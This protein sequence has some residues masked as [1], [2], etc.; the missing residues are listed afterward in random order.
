MRLALFS[1]IH[2]EFEIWTPP[3][4]D[5]DVVVLAGDIHSKHHG[6]QWAKE[7]FELPVI[8]ILG[9]HEYY[10]FNIQSI[11]RKLKEQSKNSNVHVLINESIEID[12]VKFIGSTLWSD[13]KLFGESQRQACIFNAGAKMNDFQ[14]ISINDNGKYRKLKVSDTIAF[15]DNSLNF[16]ENELK[17]S[18]TNRNI[19]VTHHAPSP[20]STPK[21]YQSDLL[22]AAFSSNLEEFIKKYTNKIDVWAHG[23]TH[24]SVNYQIADTRII[25]NQRGYSSIEKFNFD[26]GY[27]VE[28]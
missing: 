22:S 20:Q 8:Y 24:H 6:I 7:F 16:I 23:H 18:N 5:A 15:F 3:K 9:N 10:G 21:Q 19:V 17:T 27:I 1:D 4:I 28:I 11:N 25:S 12:G 26:C 14:R 13:F 2:N